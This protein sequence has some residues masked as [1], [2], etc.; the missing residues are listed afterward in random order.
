M[1]RT[2]LEQKVPSSWSLVDGSRG[3]G[4]QIAQTL[5]GS[6]KQATHSQQACG[7]ASSK[8]ARLCPV[9]WAEPIHQLS[10][11]LP[12]R[13]SVGLALAARLEASN[14]V[15]QGWGLGE[16]LGGAVCAMVMDDANRDDIPEIFIPFHTSGK[17]FN[18][19]SCE[20]PIAGILGFCGETLNGDPSSDPG[21]GPG[22]VY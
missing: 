8:L 15:R 5:P 7:N 16:P 21:H 4:H 18:W 11:S 10:C 9:P 14:A 1:A 20:V 12:A 2:W 22:S 3:C 6:P 19:S 13:L 17:L